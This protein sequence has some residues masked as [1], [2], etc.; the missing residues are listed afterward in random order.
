MN[1]CFTILKKIIFKTYALESWTKGF[2]IKIVQSKP[3][4]PRQNH[5]EQAKQWVT[6]LLARLGEWFCVGGELLLA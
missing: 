2:N 5:P 6:P 1:N 3:L 4:T